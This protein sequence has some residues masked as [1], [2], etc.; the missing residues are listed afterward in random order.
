MRA[1]LYIAGPVLWVIS[2]LVVDYVVRHGREIGI[3]LVVLGI[4]FL[5]SLVFLIPMRM[6]RVR[7]EKETP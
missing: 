2:F 5:V 7:E 4:S 1:V 3:A 6:R